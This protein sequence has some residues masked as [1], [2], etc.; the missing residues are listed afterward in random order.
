MVNFM[1]CY[2][3]HLCNVIKMHDCDQNCDSP[4]TDVFPRF[5]SNTNV[6][7]LPMYFHFLS[8]VGWFSVE[9]YLYR[10]PSTGNKP[11]G[12]GLLQTKRSTVGI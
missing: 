1:V 9:F 10:G 2:H 12:R 11:V 3:I 7:S 4:S 5:L 8:G 6:F